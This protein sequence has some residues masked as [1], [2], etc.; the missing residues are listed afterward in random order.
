M[1]FDR[2]Y[3]RYD[4]PH[5]VDYRT[6]YDYVVMERQYILR[7]DAAFDSRLCKALAACYELQD[8]LANQISEDAGQ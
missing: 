2:R 5:E 7:R 3:E 8:Y 6:F 4:L 1:Y